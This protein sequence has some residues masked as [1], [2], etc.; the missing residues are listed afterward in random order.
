VKVQ[1]RLLRYASQTL[2][3]ANAEVRLTGR[4]NANYSVVTDR[5]GYFE[6]SAVPPG[7]YTAVAATT[8]ERP[9]VTVGAAD[10]T[11][12][13]LTS[14]PGVRVSGRMVQERSNPVDGPQRL[15]WTGPS[16]FII[17]D[18][19]ADG[20][21]SLSDF[22]QGIYRVEVEPSTVMPPVNITVRGDV[23]DLLLTIPSGFRVAGTIARQDLGLSNAPS[24]EIQ[25]QGRASGRATIAPDGTFTF[26]RVVPGTY[27]V[28]IT[29]TPVVGWPALQVVVVDR[30]VTGIRWTIPDP[31]KMDLR[32]LIE[33][34]NMSEQAWGA[35]IAGEAARTEL[36]PLLEKALLQRLTT[37]QTD[38]TVAWDMPI[39]VIDTISDALIRFDA[40]LPLFTVR[41]LF[42]GHPAQALLLASKMDSSADSFLLELL[43]NQR[44]LPW[45]ATANLLMKRRTP[46]F[47]ASLLKKLRLE[48]HMTVCDAEG[49]CFG[50]HR[51]I[52]GGVIDYAD[53]PGGIN[54][55]PWPGY[56]F[57]P[58]PCDPAMRAECVLVAPGPVPVSIE[59][60]VGDSR[61]PPD[62][63][64]TDNRPTMQDR[65]MYV[66]AAAPKARVSL[67]D[68]EDRATP[69][70]GPAAL[71][72]EVESFRQDILSRYSALL[73]DLLAAGLL[74]AEEAEALDKPNLTVTVDN[75]HGN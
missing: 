60:W 35:W 68:H 64:H 21:F 59:R 23:A 37:P 2:G 52:G 33:S 73:K 49:A 51:G 56:R 4:A 38:R 70:R 31:A 15:R 25:L 43:E 10:V 66:Q 71:N 72:A 13:V 65:L 69:W 30:D 63:G 16:G 11:D 58:D 50:P 42:A 74:T 39:L 14:Q 36:T 62:D 47:A 53:G 44:Q 34:S 67:Q 27:Q 20:S 75:P 17:T 54:L 57:S 6:F 46:G 45:F 26:S 9:V 18:V 41:S 12:L 48:A 8:W 1:G 5:N 7:K 22:P 40:R 55:P 29:P 24:G 3:V 28:K 61:L 32:P 19:A